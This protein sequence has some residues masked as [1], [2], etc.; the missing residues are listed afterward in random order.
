MAYSGNPHILRRLYDSIM[1]AGLAGEL[2]DPARR[3]A[4]LRKMRNQRHGQVRRILDRVL[5]LDADQQAA[6]FDNFLKGYGI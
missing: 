2:A 6:F 4:V 3:V 5:A 1:D